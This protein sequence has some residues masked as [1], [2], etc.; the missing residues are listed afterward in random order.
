[1]AYW[2]LKTVRYQLK[3]KG[4]T[5]DWRE[6]VRVMNTQK[7]V[8]TSMDND[9]RQRLSIRCCFKPETKVALLYDALHM[10]QV[11]FIRKKSVVLKIEPAKIQFPDLLKD[12][13]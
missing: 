10:K 5:S 7:G 2:V 9:K 3:S 4:I 12:T 11:P 13:S 8:T 1:M 6:L